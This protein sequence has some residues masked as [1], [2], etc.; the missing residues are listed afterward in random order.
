MGSRMRV[1]LLGWLVGLL[2]T[3][4]PVAVE[5]KEAD[6]A[7]LF[8]SFRGNGQDGLHLSW[9]ADGLAWTPLKGDRSFLTPAVGG[10]LMR[11]PHILQGPDG[12]F[13]MVWT[14]GWWDKGIGLAHSKDLITWS[15]QTF[16]P[17]MEKTPGTLNAWAP[18]II[19]DD[20]RREYVIF[21]SSTVAGRFPETADRGDIRSDTGDGL[22]HR[23]YAVTTKNFKSFSEP[24]LLYDPGFV[25]IDATIFKDGR[26][27]VMFIKDETRRPTAEKNIRVAIA[28]SPQGPYGPASEPFTPEG[29]WVEGPTVAKIGDAFYVYYDAY[30]S[31]RMMG[32]KSKDLIHWEDISDRLSFPKGTRHGS[33]LETRR[34]VLDRLLAAE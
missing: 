29:V 19:W 8:A 18:E 15:E 26:R 22:N 23:V 10:K 25:S 13:H 34:A 24:K 12:V 5:A 32:A 28:A 7:L 20:Q 27:Y 16:L 17:V 33:V 11:D 9:S 6:K 21:W 30:T 2:F 31:H 14:T 1:H 3:L 4:A